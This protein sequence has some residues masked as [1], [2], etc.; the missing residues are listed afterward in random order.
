MPG[1]NYFQQ[2]YYTA[3]VRIH[4][5]IAHQVVFRWHYGRQEQ[6]PYVPASNPR[7]PAQQARRWIF[8]HAVHG[9]RTLTTPQRTLYNQR[10]NRRGRLT[11]FNLYIREYLR[12]YAPD[13]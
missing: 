12:A 8:A 2:A 11:G 3:A 7:T 1:F 4:G 9:W 13:S 6:Y 10:A 5:H